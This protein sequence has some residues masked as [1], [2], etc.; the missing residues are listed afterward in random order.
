V[1][2]VNGDRIDDLVFEVVRH[3]A[4]ASFLTP[5]RRFDLHLSPFVADRGPGSDPKQDLK[6]TTVVQ[7]LL[8]GGQSVDPVTV[9]DL[10]GDGRADLVFPR[11]GNNEFLAVAARA[12][13]VLGRSGSWPKAYRLDGI[14][15]GPSIV[16]VHNDA[17][18]SEQGPSAFT[19]LLNA[20]SVSLSTADLNHDGRQDLLMAVDGQFLIRNAIG[21]A[22]RRQSLVQVDWG[23]GEL[24]VPL[25]FRPDLTIT[26][27]G[28]CTLG[29]VGVGDVTG[30]G[31]RDLVVRRCPTALSPPQLRVIAGRES[32]PAE[33]SADGDAAPSA[34]G[35]LP[36]P[37]APAPLP[38]EPPPPSGGYLPAPRFGGSGGDVSMPPEAR[39]AD[40]N[41]DAVLDITLEFAGK[42]HVWYG[43]PQ[44]V[45]R[46]ATNR[47]QGVFVKAGYGALP[48]TRSW[49]AVDLDADGKSDLLLSKPI[50][51]SLLNCQAGPCLN[52]VT[53]D[54]SGRP[55]FL[56][57][58]SKPSRRVV[59]VDLDAADAVWDDPAA[60]LWGLGDFNGD[61]R[62]DLLMGSSPGAFDSV[63]GLVF[64]PLSAAA[65]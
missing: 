47:T 37:T 25:D 20:D 49:R 27:L 12:T 51:P 59:D 56:F 15:S 41:G 21:S 42:S 9:T 38:T 45:A 50:D 32:W 14:A 63:Y 57:A 22:V 35:I 19:A 18:F 61:G 53:Q 26:G 46:V 44:V 11:A 5:T 16:H 33:L 39:L 6:A 62:D 54:A 60:V 28:A 3:E 13:V 2:D 23:T 7:L 52:F 48:L 8:D 30:D 36:T 65:P 10:N 58:G 40:V 31:R 29:L 55:V 1:G 43:G 17:V 64:G 4:G 24:E 34:P